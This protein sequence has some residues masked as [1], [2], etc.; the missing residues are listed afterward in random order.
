MKTMN[1][2]E[3]EC[4]VETIT[5]EMAS[6]LLELNTSNRPLNQRHVEFLVEEIK[7]GRWRLNGESIKLNGTRLLDGQHRLTAIA[8]CGKAVECLIV[9]GIS[10]DSFQ[11]ID[12]TRRRTGADVLSI[13]GE[14]YSSSLAAALQVI[15]AYRNGNF[16]KAYRL[17]ATQIQ[18]EL[19]LFPGCR[20]SVVKAHQGSCLL[21]RSVAA[22]FHYL[23]SLVD[24]CIADQFLDDLISGVGLLP[25]DPVLLLRN[26]LIENQRSSARLV[27]SYI[28]AL[29]IKALNARL[30]GISIKVLRWKSDEDFPELVGLAPEKVLFAARFLQTYRGIE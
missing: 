18:E 1:Q 30:S 9:R 17:H 26:R 24:P 8:T 4:T 27:K 11:T 16:M 22:G 5:P 21:Q 12:L 10:A 23:A 20:Q 6:R 25:G 14:Q 19:A 13:A 3:L 15:H 2:S 7:E 29:T 28:A